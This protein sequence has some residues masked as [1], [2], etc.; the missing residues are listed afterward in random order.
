VGQD[1]WGSGQVGELAAWS[2]VYETWR[3]KNG[4]SIAGGGFYF[5]FVDYCIVPKLC[6]FLFLVLIVFGNTCKGPITFTQ[7]EF[8]V[9]RWIGGVL[10][11]DPDV[12]VLSACQLAV[13][14]Y[15]S[16]V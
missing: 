5:C 14:G 15:S 4:V 12:F 13:H 9:E 11:W 1:R 7:W 16:V 6:H 2:C 8:K 10:L 3:L